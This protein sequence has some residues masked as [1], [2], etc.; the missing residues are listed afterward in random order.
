MKKNLLVAALLMSAVGAFAQGT[1][2][3]NNRATAGTPPVVA[4]IYGVD[5][6]CPTC[7]KHGN[8]ATGAI[9]PAPAGTQTYGG[10]LVTGTGFTAAIWGVNVNLAD[11]ALTDSAAQPLAVAPFRVAGT[12]ESLKGF[13]TGSTPAVPGVVGGGAERAKFIIR[14]WDNRG[15]T[16][17]TWSQVLADASIPRGDSGIFTVNQALGL[18]PSI[19]APTLEGFQSFQ[20]FIVPE[21]SVIALGVLG[22]GCLF[23]LR[24]RK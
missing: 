19:P 15:G 1:I 3:F 9:Q 21:P 7:E 24:R 17:T 12:T 6:A 11:T 18:A 2:T 14:V 22:A 23:L 10:Q 16:I 20:L 4:P 5:P 8:T 13:W